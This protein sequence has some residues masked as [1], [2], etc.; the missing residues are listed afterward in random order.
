[1][2]LTP[3]QRALLTEKEDDDYNVLSISHDEECEC[4]GAK[5]WTVF[6]CS[7]GIRHIESLAAE[8]EKSARLEEELETANKWKGGYPSKC[9]ITGDENVHV[10]EWEGEVLAGYG[11][12]VNYHTIPHVDAPV[13][14]KAPVQLVHDIFDDDFESHETEMLGWYV[15]TEEWIGKQEEAIDDKDK[16]IATLEAENAR[17]KEL[18]QRS[19]LEEVDGTTVCPDG[20]GKPIIKKT[21]KILVH[22]D[23]V[24]S[25]KEKTSL[26]QKMANQSR[27]IAAL[28]SENAR[29]REALPPPEKLHIL[30]DWFEVI[31]PNMIFRDGH[32][33]KN[34]KDEV[35]R[36]L[37]RWADAIDA[38]LGTEPPK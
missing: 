14:D 16:K 19:D 6:Y 27:R 36:D 38:A 1:M 20:C 2:P 32:E 30:A 17:L 15:V 26:L 4:E 24:E 33:H 21:G 31:F 9:P 34:S 25:V 28:E 35:Q 18:I 10:F 23:H 5:S 29:L 7:I 22:K 8:R 13:N 37:K 11:T 12:V 3:E